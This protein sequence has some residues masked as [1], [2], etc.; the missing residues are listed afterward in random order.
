MSVR[1]AASP[2]ARRRD[3]AERLRA[4]RRQIEQTI[5]P[6]QGGARG[7]P[8]HFPRSRT[9]RLLLGEPVLIG[10]V[11]A[12]ATR[13][14]GRRAVALIP[15]AFALLRVWR[16]TMRDRAAAAPVPVRQVPPAPAA[17]AKLP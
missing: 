11:A 16:K 9:L 7:G 17:V 3:L 5:S 10:A 2:A 12:L 4:Q 6:A 14:L 15:T 1:E 8:G 13:V